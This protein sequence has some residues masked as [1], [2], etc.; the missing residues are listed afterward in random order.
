MEGAG[1]LSH[2]AQVTLVVQ[3]PAPDFS[4]SASPSSQTVSHGAAASYTVTITPINGFNGAVSLSVTSVP[5]RSSASFNPNPT[6]SASTLMI[7]TSRKTTQRTYTLAIT[8][9][10]GGLSRTTT[11]QLIVQ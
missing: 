2:T 5:P 6:T 9:S 7:S 3:A 11:V 1:T 8:G 10:S 4:V